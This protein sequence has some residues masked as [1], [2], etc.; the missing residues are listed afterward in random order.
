M[1]HPGSESASTQRRASN[2]L[3]LEMDQH[4]FYE[5]DKF[6]YRCPDAPTMAWSS[7][8]ECDVVTC[9]ESYSHVDSDGTRVWVRIDDLESPELRYAIHRTQLAAL[10]N[11]HLQPRSARD[12]HS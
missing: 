2:Q 9:F 8:G 5:S 10:Q 11:R 3:A 1:E 6:V 12:C 7:A 4:S